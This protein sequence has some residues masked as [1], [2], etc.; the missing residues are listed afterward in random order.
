MNITICDRC[1][2]RADGAFDDL[3]IGTMSRVTTTG[4]VDICRSCHRE[5]MR[6][7]NAAK[8]QPDFG[9]WQSLQ[10]VAHD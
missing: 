5:F 2:E 8:P 4:L 1:G 9:A 7:W 3:Q 10:E 6:W